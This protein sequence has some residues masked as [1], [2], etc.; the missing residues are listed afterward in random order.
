M[1]H[2]NAEAWLAKRLG[3]HGAG[4]FTGLTD[5]DIRRER[6]RE[7][8]TANLL[9]LVI[10]GATDRKPETYEQAFERVYGE[11]LKATKRKART[12]LPAVSAPPK[13]ELR[14]SRGLFQPHEEHA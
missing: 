12:D 4:V 10:I 14:E 8:I 7:A 5:P 11:P 2:L 13:T 3:E 6:I 1:I 9:E